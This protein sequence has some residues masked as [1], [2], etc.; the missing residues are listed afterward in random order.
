ML[1]TNNAY[2]NSWAASGNSVALLQTIGRN[3]LKEPPKASFTIAHNLKKVR[4]TVKELELMQLQL[5]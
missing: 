1:L 2:V 3:V 4:E 5:L